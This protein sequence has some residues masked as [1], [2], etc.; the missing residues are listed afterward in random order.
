MKL[1][2]CEHCVNGNDFVSR[3]L[4]DVIGGIIELVCDNLKL[5]Q[6]LTR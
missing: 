4:H 2:G 5:M 3:Y 6:Y 1:V